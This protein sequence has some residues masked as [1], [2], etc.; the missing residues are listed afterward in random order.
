MAFYELYIK[1]GYKLLSPCVK[2]MGRIH[3]NIFT[4]SSLVCAILAALCL[5][6]GKVYLLF[7]SFFVFA[8]SVLDMLDGEVARR[9]NKISNKGD[10]LDKMMDTYS[11]ILIILGIAFS[12]YCKVVLGLLALV[13]VLLVRFTSC[14]AEI[15]IGTRIK[16]GVLGRGERNILLIIIPV[17]QYLLVNTGNPRIFSLF[18]MEWL[19]IVFIIF[20]CV[21]AVERFYKALIR[22]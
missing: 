19:M 18:V 17:I 6:F 21:A 11:D 14:Q 15:D 20:G 12:A 10:F 22:L 16:G 3:P 2:R 4:I 8:N 13:V 5:Y 9:F 1:H 7:G